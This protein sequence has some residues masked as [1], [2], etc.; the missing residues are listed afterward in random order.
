MKGVIR[1][2]SRRIEAEDIVELWERE[3]MERLRRERGGR[4]Q[5]GCEK[6]INPEREAIEKEIKDLKKKLERL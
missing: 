6:R 5:R 2:K 3:E 1:E 4:G